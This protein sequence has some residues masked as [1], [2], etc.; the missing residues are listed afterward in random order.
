MSVER[1]SALGLGF[2]NSKDKETI[3]RKG[4]DEGFQQGYWKAK[5]ELE[6]RLDDLNAKIERVLEADSFKTKQIEEQNTKMQEMEGRLRLGE[7]QM[8]LLGRLFVELD[9]RQSEM[10]AETKDILRR[11]DEILKTPSV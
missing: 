9:K 3:Y 6:S 5:K 10:T 7:N 4:I 2:L 11:I 1:W 8:N